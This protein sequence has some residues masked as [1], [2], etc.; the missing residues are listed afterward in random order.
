MYMSKKYYIPKKKK[1]KGLII[2]LIIFG[3]LVVLPVGFAF[4]AFFTTSTKE[5]SDTTVH[6]E[7]IVSESLHE[8]IKKLDKDNPQLDFT[9]NGDMIDGIMMAACEKINQPDYIP[10]MYCSINEND[11]T[12]YADLQASFFKTRVAIAT[13]LSTEGEGDARQLVFKINNIKV[14]RLPIPVNWVISILGNFLNDE[15]LNNAFGQSGFHITSDLANARLLYKRETFKEDVG[16]Y[17]SNLGNDN[18]FLNVLLSVF[19]DESILKTNFKDGVTA[20]FD[21][22][23]LQMLTDDKTYKHKDAPLEF[24]KLD[25][26]KDQIAS[27]LDRHGLEER[28]GVPNVYTYLL[29]GYNK[30][31][32]ATRTYIENL[33]GELKTAIKGLTEKEINEYQGSVCHSGEKFEVYCKD[34]VENY[35]DIISWTPEIPTKVEELTS[36]SFC[37]PSDELNSILASKLDGVIG[38]TTPITFKEGDLWYCDYVTVD[39]VYTGFND[40]GAGVTNPERFQFN[41]YLRLNISGAPVTIV[42]V[43]NNIGLEN[44]TSESLG[45][46]KFKIKDIYFGSLKLGDST[47]INQIINLIP[48]DGVFCYNIDKEQFEVSID[49]LLPNST[50]IPKEFIAAFLQ[51]KELQPSLDKV[52]DKFVLEYSIN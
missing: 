36:V 9:I 39:N 24:T 51:G 52:N 23:A 38:S 25:T 17:L 16:V 45:C 2:F 49:D 11:Y 22:K 33:S 19:G 35:K 27:L 14:G 37:L 41:L 15:T 47:L 34:T 7:N 31:P 48:K 29:R 26:Y 8:G 13:H 4:G 21:L 20:T 46:L 3:I 44:S 40:L 12:F 1:H 30:S 10:K 32:E 28:E 5:V 42:I 50:S 6:Y 18:P 43:T